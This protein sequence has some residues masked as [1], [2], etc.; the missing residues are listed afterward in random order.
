MMVG[1]YWRIFAYWNGIGETWWIYRWNRFR[2]ETIQRY[3]PEST[4]T[5]LISMFDNLKNAGNAL[6][7]TFQVQRVK[8]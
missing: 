3:F 4:I 5:K 8:V 6:F 2:T 7:E 1:E